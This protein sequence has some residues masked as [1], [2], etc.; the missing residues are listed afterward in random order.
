MSRTLAIGILLAMVVPGVSS[1]A[2]TGFTVSGPPPGM[3]LGNGLLSGTLLAQR[4]IDRDWGPSDDS[5][6][7]EV[8]IP[9]LKSEALA[10]SLSAML[11]GAGQLYSQEGSGWFFAAIEAAG[12]GSWMWYRRDARRLHD[13]AAGLAGPPS[14]PA[15][16]WSFDRWATA[17]ESDPGAIAALYAAD[18]EAFYN[19][20]ASDPR[21]VSGWA[22]PDDRT[23][24]SSLRIRS[25]V[26]LAHSRSVATVLWFNHLIAAVDAL[27]AARFHNLPLRQNV[28]IRIG[29]TGRRPAMAVA[30]E[31]R[32]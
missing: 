9:G 11:P 10:T 22:N 8:D 24:F 27:R 14:N 31:A 23:A 32:F 6:Y 30:L 19:A 17:S 2:A 20:I 5:V 16:A 28:G 18:P 3:R 25:D 12:W 1:A 4:T 7:V 15:S 26:R 29:G 13:D 21:Y